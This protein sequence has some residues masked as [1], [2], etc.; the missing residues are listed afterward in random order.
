MLEKTFVPTFEPVFRASER[1]VLGTLAANATQSVAFMRFGLPPS[2]G[3]IAPT[4]QPW[5]QPTGA[6]DAYPVGARVTHDNPNDGG[7]IWIYESKI[8]ANTTEPGRDGTFDRW[9]Q[10]ISPV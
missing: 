5:V 7:A 6:F 2:A 3:P 10:P 4:V 1:E 8:P 9:W